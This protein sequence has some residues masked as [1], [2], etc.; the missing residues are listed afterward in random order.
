MILHSHVGEVTHHLKNGRVRKFIPKGRLYTVS[1]GALTRKNPIERIG[2]GGYS[3]RLFVG[4]KVGRKTKWKIQDVVKIVWAVREKQKESPDA[5]ILA[6]SGIYKDVKGRR[7]V[8]PSVQVILIDF[9]GLSKEVFTK[10]MSVLAETLREEL[11]QETVI[12]EIQNRGII[13]DIYSVKE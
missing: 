7:I 10:Q 8:E 4:L 6:Q 5:S 2:Q 1:Q 12:L 11:Q 9:A 3:A 13:E